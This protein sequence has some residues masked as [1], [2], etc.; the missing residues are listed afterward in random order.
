MSL[1]PKLGLIERF[2]EGIGLIPKLKIDDEK[3][4]PI[5]DPGDL[6]NYPPPEKL[7]FRCTNRLFFRLLQL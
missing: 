1:K 7:K 2:A 6:S 4:D 3:I 5:I